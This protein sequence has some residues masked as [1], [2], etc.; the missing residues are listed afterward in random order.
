MEHVGVL[1][2]A[3]DLTGGELR[4]QP[5]GVPAVKAA[6]ARVDSGPACL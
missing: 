2:V 6:E 3:G 1:T 5:A 4:G